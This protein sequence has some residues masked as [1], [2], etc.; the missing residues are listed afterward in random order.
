MEVFV[1]GDQAC[2]TQPFLQELVNRRD[3]PY[4]LK[5]FFD[6]ATAAIRV[7]IANLSRVQRLSIPPLNDIGEFVALYYE[8]TGRSAAVENCLL[9]ISQLAFCIWF[10]QAIPCT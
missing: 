6:R 8:S 1:F 9:T 3:T 5:L 7:D 2:G 10:G 4:L